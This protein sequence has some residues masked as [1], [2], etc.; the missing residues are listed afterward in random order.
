M[1][2][3]RKAEG[4]PVVGVRSVED[5]RGEPRPPLLLKRTLVTRAAERLLKI[6]KFA[7]SDVPVRSDHNVSSNDTHGDLLHDE[8]HAEV[9]AARD[10]KVVTDERARTEGRGSGIVTAF[11]HV[12][13]HRLVARIRVTYDVL[14]V[15]ITDATDL[16]GRD[17]DSSVLPNDNI[18]GFPGC[19]RHQ[20]HGPTHTGERSAAGTHTCARFEW[21]H[22]RAHA[23]NGFTSINGFTH[24]PM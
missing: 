13:P 7:P 15:L 18:A 11:A 17:R 22:A 5:L 21:I 14:L 12:A 10:T 16:G 3:R 1:P 19:A 4:D 24:L 23:S 20:K 8:H 6:T 2:A 9:G